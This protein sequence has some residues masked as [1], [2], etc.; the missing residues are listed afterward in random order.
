MP[1]PRTFYSRSKSA[2]LRRN[3]RRNSAQRTIARSWRARKQRKTTLNERTMLANRRAIKR[4][5]K[6]IETKMVEEHTA[7]L[8]NRFRGQSLDP[9]QINQNGWDGT[10][11]VVIN[12]LGGIP[13]GTGSNE[14]VGDWITLKSLTYRLKVTGTTG[15][16][17][18]THNQ[19]GCI[20]VLDRKPDY[21]V[22]NVR[23]ISDAVF[24]QNN[25]T[26][27]DGQGVTVPMMFQNLNTCGKNQRY[28]VLRHHKLFVQPV[29]ASSVVKPEKM[30]TAT[31]KA[32]YKVKY[33]EASGLIENQRLLFFLYSESSAVPHPTFN[34][35]SRVRFEDP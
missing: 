15:L 4:I 27:L 11:M 21:N 13:Q 10:G 7:V 29:S 34:F 22:P 5:N 26:L 18:D 28:K 23:T 35:K 19:C 30:F 17:P 1:Y 9:T 16:L 25:G 33:S 24:G 32:P 6:D 3:Y 31:I 12:P 20:V 2:S 14:R 8:G